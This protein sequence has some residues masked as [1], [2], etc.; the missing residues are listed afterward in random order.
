MPRK[1]SDNIAAFIYVMMA[2][3]ALLA[4]GMVYFIRQ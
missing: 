4:A 2:C 3:A 1:N